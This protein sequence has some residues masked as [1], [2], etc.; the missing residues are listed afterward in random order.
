MRDTWFCRFCLRETAIEH[1]G[2]NGTCLGCQ[3]PLIKV[4]GS[5]DIFDTAWFP[6][7]EVA[8][9]A[10]SKPLGVALNTLERIDK[11][12]PADWKPLLNL[13]ALAIFATIGGLVLKEVFRGS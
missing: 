3:M 4:R 9:G 1:D 13:A 5:H 6:V 10:I 2:V 12:A 8:V 7:A 11:S